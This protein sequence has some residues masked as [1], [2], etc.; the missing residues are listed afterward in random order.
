MTHSRSAF[1][2]ASLLLAALALSGCG[3]GRPSDELAQAVQMGERPVAMKGSG[4]FFAG[5]IDATITIARGIGKGLGGNGPGK[6]RGGDRQ[7]MPDIS[8]MENEDAMIYLRAKAAVGSPLPPVTLHLKLHNSGKDTVSVEVIDFDSDLGNFAVHPSVLSLAPDQTS[9]PDAMVSQ[10]GVSND[11]IPV[12]V[13]LRIGKVKETQM[14]QVRNI[15]TP[16]N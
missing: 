10:L 7:E 1:A 5:Q 2:L 16:S 11:V 13:T 8:G 12:K 6:H 3:G 4:S 15:L 9:E 14:V